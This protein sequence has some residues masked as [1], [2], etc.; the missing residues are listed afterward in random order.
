MNRE[1]LDSK[2]Q[3]LYEHLA[4]LRTRLIHS[5]YI[6]FLSTCG[7]YYFSEDIFNLVRAPIIPFLQ[8]GGLIF[9][10]PMD[11]FVAHL[12]LSL[13]FG[14]L[15][16]CPLLFYQAWKFIAPGLYSREKKYAI[17]FICTGTGLF[18][19]GAAFSYFIALP[20]A[21][22]FLMSFGGSAD[23]PMI[24]INEY[25]GFFSQMCLMFGVAFELPLVLVILGMMGFVS[26]QFLRQNRR[27]AV[28]VIA[29]VAAIIT[30]PDVLSM[31]LMLVPM[32]LLFEVA[33]F[34]V[35]FFERKRIESYA[36]NERE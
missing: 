8:G 26:Q 12:K 11:K 22:E 3:S 23:K 30:P 19:L 18:F 13:V 35:G 27:Y 28:M 17:G 2:A 29:I 16:S 14:I 4:E 24:S 36:I 9:T 21:F 25:M 15:V 1:E 7:T 20:M 10:H 34:L 6:L 33:V 5:A 32:W 31:L